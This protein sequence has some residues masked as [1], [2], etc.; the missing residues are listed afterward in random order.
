MK[1][2][3]MIL[4]AAMLLAG[5]FSCN[6]MTAAMINKKPVA[7]AG[8]DITAS[9]NTKVTL[10]GTNSYDPEGKGL[11]YNWFF[12]SAPLGAGASVYDYL[13]ANPYFSPDVPGEYV[14]ILIVDDGT[15]ESKPDKVVITVTR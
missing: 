13:T 6:M 12:V 11:K 5:S 2:L 3:L 15:D 7:N 4:A 10:N 1:K 14:V 9:I 8:T